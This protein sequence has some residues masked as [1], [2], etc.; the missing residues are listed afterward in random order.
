MK[1]TLTFAAL[2]FGLFLFPQLPGRRSGLPAPSVDAPNTRERP[3]SEM[4]EELRA[5][6]AIKYAEKEI[7]GDPSLRQRDRRHHRQG[8][9]KGCDQQ[10]PAP[11]PRVVKE[12]R[13][14]KSLR[15]NTQRRRRRRSELELQDR[16]ADVPS[17][18]TKIAE[19]AELLSKDVQKKHSTTGRFNNSHRKC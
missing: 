4:E 2:I 6:Q 3:L 8:K 16:P 9:T 7:S 13:A 5:K 12:D 17:A 15:V 19:T 18:I 11:E 10:H 14:L 1:Y